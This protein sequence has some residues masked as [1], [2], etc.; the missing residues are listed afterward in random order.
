MASLVEHLGS[1]LPRRKV[2]PEEAKNFGGAMFAIDGLARPGM[3][4]T[5]LHVLCP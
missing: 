5:K 3:E 1:W 2:V 4:F